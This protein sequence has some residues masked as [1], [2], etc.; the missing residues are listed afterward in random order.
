MKDANSNCG[1]ICI[2]G[3]KIH[4]S[5]VFAGHDVGVRQVE[6]DVWLVSF[7]DY[8]LGYFDL[9]SNKVQALDNPFG[10]KV[11]RVWAVKSVNHVL[12][13]NCQG[14]DQYVPL[15][16]GGSGETRT[17]DQR[18]KSPL[19]YRL[20]YRPS[21]VLLDSI[22]NKQEICLIRTLQEKPL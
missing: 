10:P 14:C 8:D 13:T 7:M 1:R 22:L 11:L 15:P 3:Q 12:G 9:E 18:I 21:V 19:L 16:L 20:S 6:D 17:R 2:A 5:T 4:L